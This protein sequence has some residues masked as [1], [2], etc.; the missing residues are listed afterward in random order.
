[1]LQTLFKMSV[2]DLNAHLS[3]VFYCA[4]HCSILL[5]W[6][7][8]LCSSSMFKPAHFVISSLNNM[9]NFSLKPLISDMS[10]LLSD[11]HD[12]LTILSWTHV[13]R[14]LWCKVTWLLYSWSLAGSFW[15]T[16]C[17]S[18]W[19]WGSRMVSTPDLVQ[20]ISWHFENS[21]HRV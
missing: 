8:I 6:L 9:W 15:I 3:T 21:N 11:Y 19:I 12:S 13:N 20:C 2:C 16:L 1:M 4:V 18:N 5:K 7:V 10:I 17:T 14:T